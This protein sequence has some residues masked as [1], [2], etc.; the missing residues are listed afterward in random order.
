[1]YQSHARHKSADWHFA[2]LAPDLSSTIETDFSSL[3]SQKGGLARSSSELSDYDLSAGD[4]S[5]NKLGQSPCYGS[6]TAQDGRARHAG[7]DQTDTRDGS[8]RTIPRTDSGGKDTCGV[9]DQ[10]GRTDSRG[11]TTPRSLSYTQSHSDNDPRGGTD[12]RGSTDAGMEHC[13]STSPCDIP[14]TQRDRQDSTSQRDRQDSTGEPY[15]F[16]SRFQV[17]FEEHQQLVAEKEVYLKQRQVVEAESWLVSHARQ[18][19]SLSS[20]I[21]QYKSGGMLVH[22]HRLS[23]LS[24]KYCIR[25]DKKSCAIHFCASVRLLLCC[26]VVH[27]SGCPSV[28]LSICL[29]GWGSRLI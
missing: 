21:H 5:Y 16:R 28:R 8:A 26:R 13:V 3:A 10:R 20:G 27:P 14:T 24:H 29:S 9:A 1:M 11:A 18:Q 2:D 19:R 23:H 17:Y 12:I 22:V 4:F 7:S 6:V 25:C 15:D